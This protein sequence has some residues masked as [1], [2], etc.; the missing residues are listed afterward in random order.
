MR[1]NCQ[2]KVGLYRAPET[3]NG[4]ALNWSLPVQPSLLL[5]SHLA[6]WVQL[7]PLPNA[8]CLST[9]ALLSRFSLAIPETMVLL[10]KPSQPHLRSTL[11]DP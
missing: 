5:M 10:S 3:S 2:R 1:K 9:R 11:Q 6:P 4:A 7:P 8:L